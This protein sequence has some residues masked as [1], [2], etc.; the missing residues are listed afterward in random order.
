MINTEIDKDCFASVGFGNANAV[1]SRR[2]FTNVM[3]CAHVT[4]IIEDHLLTDS[5]RYVI[6]IC[7]AF[8]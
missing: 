8:I 7:I 6:L 3:P 1:V 5:T 2:V 4:D